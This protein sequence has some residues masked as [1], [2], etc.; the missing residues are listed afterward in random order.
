MKNEDTCISI[1]PIQLRIIS[2]T[3]VVL[4]NDSRNL[5][6]FKLIF[7]SGDDDNI[8]VVVVIYDVVADDVHDQPIEADDNI[9]CCC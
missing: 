4:I 8:V 9:H 5:H 7:V 6:I 1:E 2:T 3:V